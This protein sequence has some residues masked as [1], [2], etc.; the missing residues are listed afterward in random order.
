MFVII[1]N[2]QNAIPNGVNEIGAEAF[3]HNLLTTIIIP[4]NVTSPQLLTVNV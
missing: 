4:D 2:P 1:S 3:S